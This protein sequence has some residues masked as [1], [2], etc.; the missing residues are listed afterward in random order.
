MIFGDLLEVLDPEPHPAALNMAIDE[1]LLREATGPLLRVY[2]WSRPSVSMGY[3]DKIAE[4]ERQWPERELV[5][6][7]TGGGIV[8]HGE[9]LTYTLIVPRACEFFEFNAVESYSQIHEAIAAVM[10]RMNGEIRLAPAAAPKISG[11]C[12]ENPARADIIAGDRKI[13]GAAQRR[14]R[15]GLLHQGSIQKCDVAGL[16]D[17]LPGAFATRVIRREL[18]RA[19]VVTA[20]K[21]VEERYGREDWLRRF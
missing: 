14:T 16:R 7:W 17:R 1:I 18:E 12:F 9:D 15:Y 8:P 19:V 4:V 10:G 2:S 13:A 20:E 5:R 6:R 3:F 11:A 21:L